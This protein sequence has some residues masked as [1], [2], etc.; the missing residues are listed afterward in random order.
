MLVFDAVSQTPFTSFHRQIH[1]SPTP[2]CQ[3]PHCFNRVIR[4]LAG[5]DNT[6][7][8]AIVLPPPRSSAS[9]S[10]AATMPTTNLSELNIVISVLGAFTVL[11]GI[12]SVK[13]KQ[14]WYLGEALP[15]VAIGIILG[16]V[17]AKFIESEQWGN[18]EPG[19]TSAITLVGS[20]TCTP[21]SSGGLD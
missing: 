8:H 15:A 9:F 5:Q 12:I 18:A 16:P 4:C 2:S 1:I 11:Y 21:L 13:I 3:C 10:T 6:P 19:Q 20:I 14:V 17:A 7:I